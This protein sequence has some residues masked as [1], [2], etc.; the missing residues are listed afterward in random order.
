MYLRHAMVD[1]VAVQRMVYV[2]AAAPLSPLIFP[3]RSV[4]EHIGADSGQPA[5]I[6]G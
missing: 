1:E 5:T 2:L 4:D 3:W 6:S